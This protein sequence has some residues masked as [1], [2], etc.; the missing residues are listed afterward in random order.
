MDVATLP[1]RRTKVLG[2]SSARAEA[3]PPSPPPDLGDS[4]GTTTY[5]YSPAVGI[6]SAFAKHFW[7]L[8]RITS[9]RSLLPQ[10]ADPPSPLAMEWARQVLRTL[11]DAEFPP[12][13]VTASAEGGVA[14]C[15]V[16]G[17]RYSD[18][19]CLNTGEILGVT[20]DRK[21]RPTAWEVD[22]SPRGISLS[23]ARIRAF[24]NS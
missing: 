22:P 20:S 19:E 13:T 18:L 24:L 23:I 12:E 1:Y 21:N 10:D 6:G 2:D 17:E 11:R 15:F 16:N 9:D 3:S 5:G 14:V 4:A 8:K 7:K